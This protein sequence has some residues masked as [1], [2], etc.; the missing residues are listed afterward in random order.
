EHHRAHGSGRARGPDL[1]PRGRAAWGAPNPTAGGEFAHWRPRL[2]RPGARGRVGVGGGRADE[3]DGL[4]RV[5]AVPR[6]RPLGDAVAGRGNPDRHADRQPAP[7]AARRG[8]ASLARAAPDRARLWPALLPLRRDLGADDAP[9]PGGR[10]R[11]GF[12]PR[13]R[14][15][16][17]R[18]L[19]RRLRPRA[20]GRLLADRSRALG[21]RLR[22]HRRLR[23]AAGRL[24]AR[25]GRRAAVDRRGARGARRAPLAAG[26]VV[27][28]PRRAGGERRGDGAR[29]AL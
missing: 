23:R 29:C 13:Q 12:P 2:R 28:R 27:H 22:L 6:P 15:D 14:P 19:D 18:R 25:A 1:H 8:A 16:D 4:L 9:F 5:G 17:G 3:H 7:P 11:R 24:L 21:P 20:G 10:A 26:P